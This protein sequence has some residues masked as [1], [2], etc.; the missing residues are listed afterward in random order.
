MTNIKFVIT[1]SKCPY[2]YCNMSNSRRNAFASTVWTFTAG[3]GVAYIVAASRFLAE[4][5]KCVWCSKTTRTFV[6]VLG[7]SCILT[8][9]LVCLFSILSMVFVTTRHRYIEAVIVGSSYN[10]SIAMLMLSFLLHTAY[11]RIIWIGS[12]QVKEAYRA[13]YILGYALAGV[14]ALWLVV[15]P[16]VRKPTNRPQDNSNNA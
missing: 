5:F 6:D 16:V 4:G 15:I 1:S 14:Y 13:T 7:A 3:L 11:P 8:M 12:H 10:V 2:S 9:I